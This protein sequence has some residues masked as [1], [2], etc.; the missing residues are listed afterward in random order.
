MKKNYQIPTEVDQW[1]QAQMD[2]WDLSPKKL[3]S[4]IQLLSDY[5]VFNQGA[6]TPWSDLST[7]AAYFTYYFP[8]NLVR[9]QSLVHEAQRLNFFEGLEEVFDFG[10]GLGSASLAL[11]YANVN[12][13]YNLIESSNVPQAWAEKSPLAFYKKAVWGQEIK[14]SQ[15]KQAPR[16]LG[17]FSYSLI[18]QKDVPEWLFDFEALMLIEPSTQTA[19]R[20]LLEL[21]SVLIERG[22]EIW[23]PCLHQNACPLIANSKTDW[24]HHRLGFEAPQLLEGIETYLPMKN[25][26]LTYSY[27]LARKKKSGRSYSNLTARVI[28]DPL[29]EKGKT[30]QMICRSSEREFLSVLDIENLDMNL[31]RGDIIE[32]PSEALH[33]GTELRIKSAP[34]VL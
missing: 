11:D 14:A 18:E 6:H 16:S 9:A 29:Y 20:K 5:F 32:I 23:A 31:D 21:R 28:G 26:T 12:L 15:L 4:A 19:G 1:I 33:K 7:G 22:Y 10:A 3:A 2:E 8:L 17:L 34:Q 27:L 30:R 25:K 24:C 13:K